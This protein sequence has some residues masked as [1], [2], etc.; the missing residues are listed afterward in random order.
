MAKLVLLTPEEGRYASCRLTLNVIL[1][2]HH[3]ATR[4]SLEVYDINNIAGVY[5]T[6][7]ATPINSLFGT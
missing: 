4:F 7:G 3:T 5:Y 6:R 1:Y 2:P